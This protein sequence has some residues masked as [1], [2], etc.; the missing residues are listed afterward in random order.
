MVKITFSLILHWSFYLS[1]NLKSVKNPWSPK[2]GFQENWWLHQNPPSLRQN[3]KNWRRKIK[4][5]SNKNLKVPPSKITVNYIFN[6][7]FADTHVCGLSVSSDMSA[8]FYFFGVCV[9]V[10]KNSRCLCLCKCLL[11]KKSECL[12]LRPKF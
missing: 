4:R 3:Q 9:C 1:K 8:F 12:C 2:I 5:E 6:Q 11:Q 10:R 7:S